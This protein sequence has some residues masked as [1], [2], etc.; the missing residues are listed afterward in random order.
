MGVTAM[1]RPRG[2]REP[3]GQKSVGASMIDHDAR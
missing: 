3:T 2:A 1:L